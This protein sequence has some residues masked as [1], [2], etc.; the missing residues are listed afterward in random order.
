MKK[1]N[2][3]ITTTFRKW[4]TVEADNEDTALDIIYN[5]YMDSTTD[6]I[7]FDTEITKCEEVK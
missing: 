3:L 4:V 2:V 7:D 6:T 5:D 1:Y